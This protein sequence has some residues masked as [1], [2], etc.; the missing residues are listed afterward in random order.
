MTGAEY[1][2]ARSKAACAFKLNGNYIEDSV[3]EYRTLEVS[4]RHELEAEVDSYDIAA[5]GAVYVSNRTQTRTLTVRFAVKADTTDALHKAMDAL[6]A[7]LKAE[8][9]QII[10]DDEPEVY[11]VGTRARI[12]LGEF[13]PTYAAGTISIFCADPYK[14][15]TRVFEEIADNNGLI[16][17]SYGGSAPAYPILSA[18]PASDAG[19]FFF[20]GA[21]ASITVGD[22]DE[23]D[24]DTVQ[25]PE[26]LCASN[27]VM[28]DGLE[29]WVQGNS[30]TIPT[31]A[32]GGL[33]EIAG[34]NGYDDLGLYAAYG[35]GAQW[36]GPTYQLDFPA[37]SNGDV[38]A[39]S[40]CAAVGISFVRQTA[41][42]RDRGR[43]YIQFNSGDSVG[44]FASVFR[45]E[46]YKASRSSEMAEVRILDSEANVLATSDSD[47][48]K[49]ELE[50][51]IL[52]IYKTGATITLI[53]P[54]GT[55][56]AEVPGIADTVVTQVELVMAQHGEDDPIEIH[57][58]TFR[59][60]K[61][62]VDTWRDLP[63]IFTAGDEVTIDC[64]ECKI[65]L[66]GND[67]PD[68]GDLDND[69][70]KMILLPGCNQ[71]RCLTSEWVMS[72]PTYSIRYREV[73][74]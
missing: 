72:A 74:L 64:G 18:R 25:L 28:R 55:M 51:A 3:P 10:F 57:A 52:H 9:S 24:G 39:V 50:N 54:A 58:E 4:G 36:H 41:S 71:I 1:W 27:F 2:A 15:S 23:V 49:G 21:S 66:N 61:Y 45:V 17:V 65:S 33:Y 46:V 29:G 38:G 48:V 34:H 70:D 43:I 44:G 12:T 59:L 42:G 68:L 5:G 62:N 16:T 14:Y 8:E 22:I 40:F 7:A 60:V 6:N 67:R 20:A 11:Y 32:Q 47:V 63:N 69:F 73:F 30:T 37:D 13:L 19:G 31:R 35:S 26:T 53:S 56:T